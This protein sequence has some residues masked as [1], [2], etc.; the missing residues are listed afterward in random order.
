MMYRTFAAALLGIVFAQ[1]GWVSQA[2]AGQ[3]GTKSGKAA[4]RAE[5]RGISGLE[6]GSSAFAIAHQLTGEIL[7]ER[8]GASVAPIAS[9]TK[10]MT[11]M[12]VLDAALPLAETLTVTRA[13]ID[14][15]KGTGSRLPIGARL[16]REQ[17][18]LLA[19]MSS[20]NRAAS[21]LARHYP[22]GEAAFIKA[23][24]VKARM[25]GLSDTQFYDSTGLSPRNVSSPRDLVRMVAAAAEY[26]LIREFTTSDERQV[27]VGRKML[28][29]RNS[30]SLVRNPE[31]NIG[32]S[33]TGFI[34]EAGRC[35]VM[36]TQLQGEPVIIVLMNARSRWA[37]DTD[38][39][40]LR[41]WLQ[42]AGLQRLALAGG[43]REG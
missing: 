6:L 10:L 41:E 23:M 11:A 3:E 14:T 36:Q 16:S 39:K 9:I 15:L 27:R 22:G 4:V 25:I 5:D 24:N 28:Q 13:D 1:L 21:A 34:R 37:R 35:V 40:R 20:E 7:A 8:R 2:A 42:T 29:Y 18:L 43:R 12:V 33:K 38:A 19:L 17:M 26:P 31:W 30:N 32:L